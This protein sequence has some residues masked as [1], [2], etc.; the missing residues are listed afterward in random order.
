MDNKS[1]SGLLVVTG[2][3]NDTN[4][5]WDKMNGAQLIKKRVRFGFGPAKSDAKTEQIILAK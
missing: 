3:H 2:G 1:E 4:V 5:P